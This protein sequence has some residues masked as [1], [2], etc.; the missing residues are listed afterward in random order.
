[1]EHSSNKGIILILSIL[2]IVV[3]MIPITGLII[4]PSEIDWLEQPR[5]ELGGH[6]LN[7]IFVD[8]NMIDYYV[9]DSDTLPNMI[10]NYVYETNGAYY[11]VQRVGIH[12]LIS[13]D[14]TIFNDIAFT[15]IDVVYIP[16]SRIENNSLGDVNYNPL[17]I[18][19]FPYH[20]N[21][22]NSFLRDSE[23][24]YNS[25]IIGNSYIELYFE[26]DVLS[27]LIEA[28]EL[29]DSINMLSLRKL[30]KK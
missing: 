9:Y 19:F 27:S 15:F 2:F 4:A 12:T 30:T 21:G 5:Y 1:M 11:Y 16:F 3:M 29:L 28:Q 25:Y 17:N 20:A 26:A 23:F 8:N 7:E 10:D 6:T 22:G 14:I 18:L 24:S 13:A